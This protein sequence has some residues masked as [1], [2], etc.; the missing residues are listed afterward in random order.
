[1]VTHMV[2]TK[3]PPIAFLKGVG[4][5][6]EP[7]GTAQLHIDEAAGRLPERY[8][9]A[10]SHRHTM[11]PDAVVN[12]CSPSHHDGRRSQYLESNP[13]RSYQFQI[14]RLAE[15]GKDIIPRMRKK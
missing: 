11:D 13:G 5:M 7:V 15:K 9:R 3:S 8:F 4:V 14:P 12:E 6:P 2:R 10:P 1:M